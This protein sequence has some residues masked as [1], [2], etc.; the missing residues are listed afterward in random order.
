MRV[1]SYHGSMP[2]SSKQWWETLFD[3]KYLVTYVDRITEA[4]SQAQLEFLRNTLPLPPEAAILDLACGYGRLSV[5]LAQA[6]YRV[7]GFDFSEYLLDI[8]QQKAQAAGL[9][10]PFVQGDMRHLDFEN[11]FDAIINIF[12][13]FGYF[14]T[15]DE[16]R[17]VLKGVHRGLKAKGY[18][19]M[20]FANSPKAISGLYENGAIDRETGELVSEKTE[21][22]SNGL[23]V[24]QVERLDVGSLRW[25]MK[26]TW[27]ERGKERSYFTNVRMY[28]LAELVQLITEAGLRVER[29]YGDFDASPYQA[30]SKRILIVSRKG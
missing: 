1:N 13:S 10:L 25:Q 7:T 5:P 28:F 17:A 14:E 26:R 6:G 9:I 18:F 2:S 3:D 23:V 22:L 12:T 11:E 8:A 20:D 15:M 29:V 30:D 24:H 16:D 27:R 21:T 19:L 4:A